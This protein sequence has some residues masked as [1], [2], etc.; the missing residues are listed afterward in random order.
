[1]EQQRTENCISEV[2]CVQGHV[3]RRLTVIATTDAIYATSP[4]ILR[5]YVAVENTADILESRTDSL[6]GLTSRRGEAMFGSLKRDTGVIR[7]R[8]RLF[9]RKC[10]LNSQDKRVKDHAHLGQAKLFFT[11]I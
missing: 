5:S 8:L 1:M 7:Y 11:A 10:G 9:V 2:L 3:D 4:Q 6:R